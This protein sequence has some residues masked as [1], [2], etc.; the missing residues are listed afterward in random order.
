M[1]RQILRCG[2][3]EQQRLEGKNVF[4]DIKR[5]RQRLSI[6]WWYGT[7]DDEQIR[8]R[9][10]FNVFFKN[11][12]GIFIFRIDT[13]TLQQNTTTLPFSLLPFH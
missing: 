13:I 6:G 12:F 3:E 10:K 7:K 8:R 4:S 11:D 5:Q 2:K 1:R 9:R